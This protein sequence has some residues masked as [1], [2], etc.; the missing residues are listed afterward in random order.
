MV[1]EEGAGARVRFLISVKDS[2]GS[3]GEVGVWPKHEN[4]G[5]PWPVFDVSDRLRYYPNNGR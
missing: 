2:R 5:I 3:L 1:K 4:L